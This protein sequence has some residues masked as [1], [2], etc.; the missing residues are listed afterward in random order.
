MYSESAHAKSALAKSTV[1]PFI[2]RI[3]FVVSVDTVMAADSR[4]ID[5]QIQSFAGSVGG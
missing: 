4:T 3:K 5:A 1:I 2:V